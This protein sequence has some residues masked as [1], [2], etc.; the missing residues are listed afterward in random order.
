MIDT[1]YYEIRTTYYTHYTLYTLYTYL[2]VEH[3]ACLLCMYLAKDLNKIEKYIVNRLRM[4]FFLYL[5]L[6]ESS[7]LP[8]GAKNWTSHRTM[9]NKLAPLSTLYGALSNYGFTAKPLWYLARDDVRS[10]ELFYHR[11]T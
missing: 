2:H 10:I 6:Y 3:I 11:V 8:Y 1:D 4:T 9:L 5:F 7:P